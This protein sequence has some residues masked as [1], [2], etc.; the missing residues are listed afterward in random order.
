MADKELSEIDSEYKSN[1]AFDPNGA[2]ESRFIIPDRIRSL[3]D[4]VAKAK[5]AVPLPNNAKKK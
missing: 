5:G 4:L 1:I 3:S 2:D